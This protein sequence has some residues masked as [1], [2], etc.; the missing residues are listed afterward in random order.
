MANLLPETLRANLERNYK[1]R[2]IIVV[3]TLLTILWAA[4]T[5]MLTP[6]FFVLSARH[7]LL[8]DQLKYLKTTK[9]NELSKE[10][11]N[12]I[13]NIRLE[14]KLLQLPSEEHFSMPDRLERIF[15]K[16]PVGVFVRAIMAPNPQTVEV[17]GRARTREDLLTFVQRLKGDHLISAIE[18]PISNLLV[19]EDA[20]FFIKISFVQ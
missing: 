14:L 12:I 3:L 2:V 13:A 16:Q 15:N 9:E 11:N 5:I 10:T 17:R 7:S 20:P 8:T 4:A 1:L 6:S 19:E 18:S